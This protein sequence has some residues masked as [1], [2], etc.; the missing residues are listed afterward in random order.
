[1]PHGGK[2]KGAGRPRGKGPWGEVTKPLRIPMSLFD[3]V[4]NFLENKGYRIPLYVSR[5]PA[6]SP[7]APTDEVEEITDINSMILKNPE[8]CFLLRVVGDSMI[9]AGIYEDDVLAVDRSIEATNGKIV[10]AMI[11][12]EATVKRFKRES[13]SF[14]LLPEN[15]DYKPIRIVE[16]PDFYIAGVVVGV[17]R[18]L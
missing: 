2:R 8:N 3:S 6:G 16:G 1:M 11:D 9:N 13:N 15:D 10:V 5:V 4:T 12:G 14:T 18:V 17:V 7:S